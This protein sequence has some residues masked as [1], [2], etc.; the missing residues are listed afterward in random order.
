MGSLVTCLWTVGESWSKPTKRPQTQNLHCKPVQHSAAPSKGEIKDI[1]KS[2]INKLREYK[3]NAVIQPRHVP[4]CYLLSHLDAPTITTSSH[5]NMQQARV[6][7]PDRSCSSAPP[8]NWCRSITT[9]H[10]MGIRDFNT[11]YIERRPPLHTVKFTV[12]RTK[13]TPTSPSQ[14]RTFIDRRQVT[15]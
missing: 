13:H 6:L 4:G 7:Q 14:S 2:S 5:P 1:F 12:L 8:L 10:K 11:L 15:R 3:K 9:Q